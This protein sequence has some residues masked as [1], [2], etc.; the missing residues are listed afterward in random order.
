VLDRILDGPEA[1][2]RPRERIVELDHKVAALEGQ[3]SQLLNLV[4]ATGRTS[5]APQRAEVGS[6]RP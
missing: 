2:G 3:V 6:P 4:E 1:D 5:M